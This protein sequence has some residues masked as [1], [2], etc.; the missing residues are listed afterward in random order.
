MG[1]A[2]Q[3]IVLYSLQALPGMVIKFSLY[4]TDQLDIKETQVLS[5]FGESRDRKEYPRKP[6]QTF[7][8][9]GFKKV[10]VVHQSEITVER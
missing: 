8:R 10:H 6:N 9:D 2:F 1:R 7:F 5:G 4:G 3:K